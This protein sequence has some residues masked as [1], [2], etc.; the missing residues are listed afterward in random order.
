MLLLSSQALF[1]TETFAM[2]INMPARTVLFTS[3]RKF[4]GKSHRF[5]RTHSYAHALSLISRLFTFCT[6]RNNVPFLDDQPPGL[7][8]PCCPGLQHG[9]SALRPCK[10]L[11]VLLLAAPHKQPRIVY[12]R[13]GGRVW[14]RRQ[15]KKKNTLRLHHTCMDLHPTH[16]VLHKQFI[17]YIWCV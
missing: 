16:A 4:D 7:C 17:W 6:F 14:N 1:A 8:K 13:R 9:A 5:V 12:M 15:T 11:I 2:G 3:A 10:V